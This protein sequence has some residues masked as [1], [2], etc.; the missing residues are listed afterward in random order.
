MSVHLFYNHKCHYLNISDFSNIF[1]K[2]FKKKII[3]TFNIPSKIYS[4]RFEFINDFF[5]I[6]KIDNK[7]LKKKS[8]R[9]FDLFDIPKKIK[10]VS[11]LIG[12]KYLKKNQNFII[13]N[14]I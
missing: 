13:K 4:S 7:F 1:T 3:G 6:N 2:I 9:D 5:K 11:K 10:M 12:L 14:V 8:I